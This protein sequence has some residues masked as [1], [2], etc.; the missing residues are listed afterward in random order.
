MER[1]MKGGS[2]KLTAFRKN[3]YYRFIIL[4]LIPNVLVHA[5]ILPSHALLHQFI[6]LI[7]D[8]VMENLAR[9]VSMICI[10]DGNGGHG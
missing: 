4:N 8:L 7:L 2:Q 5:G 9:A 1:T 3:Y 6:Q 10:K